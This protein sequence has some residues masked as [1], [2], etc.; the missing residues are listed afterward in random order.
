MMSWKRDVLKKIGKK[1]MWKKIPGTG[2]SSSLEA[3]NLSEEHR[4]R[5]EN[6]VEVQ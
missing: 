1:Q 2:H 3:K 4:D 6:M 5:K